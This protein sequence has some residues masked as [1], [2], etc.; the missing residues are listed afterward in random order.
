MYFLLALGILALMWDPFVWEGAKLDGSSLAVNPP[1]VVAPEQTRGRLWQRWP[2][3]CE[4]RPTGTV[5][6][7]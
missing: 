3:G 1:F 5:G 4:T 2:S 7:L 6:V